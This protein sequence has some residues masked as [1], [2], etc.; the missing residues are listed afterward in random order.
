MAD[1]SPAVVLDRVTVAYGKNRALREVSA[2]FPT[3]AVGLLGPNGA[4][5]STLL[6]SLLGFI[7]PTSGRLEVLGMNVAERPLE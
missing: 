6:K 2:V 7:P 3:G 1:T 5:K 4:G